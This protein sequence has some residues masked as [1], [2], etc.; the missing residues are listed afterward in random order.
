MLHEQLIICHTTLPR[1]A[2][3]NG[4]SSVTLQNTGN[5]SFYWWEDSEGPPVRRTGHWQ[6]VD[7]IFT[8]RTSAKGTWTLKGERMLHWRHNLHRGLERGEKKNRG[9]LPRRSML[10]VK[11]RTWQHRGR[12]SSHVFIEIEAATLVWAC[13]GIRDVP[14]SAAET[15]LGADQGSLKTNGSYITSNNLICKS[16]GIL[17]IFIIINC[18]FFLMFSK[19]TECIICK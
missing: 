1:P 4:H 14:P 7:F 9:L 11:K 13:T 5:N 16:E 17:F 18:L 2:H 6:K 3:W 19:M 8:S 15:S 12:M 10:K